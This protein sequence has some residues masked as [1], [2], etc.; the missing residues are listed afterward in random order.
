MYWDW[1]TQTYMTRNRHMSPRTGR[2]TQPDPHWNLENMIF[3]CEAS[4]GATFREGMPY[5]NAILQSGNLF[6]YVMHN[7]VRF[8]DSNGLFAQDD[9]MNRVE[10]GGAGAGGMSGTR[11][12]GSRPA[13]TPAPAPTNAA[14]GAVVAGAGALAVA[15]AGSAAT[16]AATVGTVVINKAVQHW[17]T[18][19]RAAE[20]GVR[21][22]YQLK[23][24]IN[25]TGLQAHHIIEQR[26]RETVVSNQAVA[27]TAAEHQAFTNKWRELLP[28]GSG[29]TFT[30]AEIW[31]HAQT[32]YADFPALLDAARIALGF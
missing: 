11:T 9:A 28:Y 2:W 12:F 8:T 3:G 4:R 27:V 24:L 18:L 26:F 7:P 29:R 23:K 19:S 20:F 32:V 13:P 22:Y 21:S 1:G 5:T 10:A 16:A 17:G 30:P 15:K 14:T 31:H 25:N 6:M